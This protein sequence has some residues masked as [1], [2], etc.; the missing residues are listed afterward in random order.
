MLPVKNY[1]GN[2][3]REGGFLYL[4]IGGKL[5]SNYPPIRLPDVALEDLAPA[6]RKKHFLRTL[7]WRVRPQDWS[8]IVAMAVKQAK[9]GS[10]EA[11]RWLS[12][13]L[14]GDLSVA[15]G[16]SGAKSEEKRLVL[17]AMLQTAEGKK[18]AAAL[19]RQIAGKALKKEE[20]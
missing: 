13:H 7:V 5:A 19:A 12:N 2:W 10:G 15:E 11:R 3:I 8:S 18:M 17:N 16:E 4:Y 6:E 20:S 9:K 14:I 1:G